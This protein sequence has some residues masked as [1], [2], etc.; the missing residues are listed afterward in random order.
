MSHE[1]IWLQ[2]GTGDDTTWCQY[3]INADDIE[4]VRADLLEAKETDLWRCTVCGRVGTVGRCC[5]EETRERANMGSLQAEIEA[6]RA[7][8]ERLREIREAAVDV[9]GNAIRQESGDYVVFSRPLNRLIAALSQPATEQLFL[10]NT[11]RVQEAAEK[12]LDELE[13]LTDDELESLI[14]RESLPLMSPKTAARVLNDE[15]QRPLGRRYRVTDTDEHGLPV[16]P[17][18]PGM[19]EGA[20]YRGWTEST[21]RWSYYTRYIKRHAHDRF[22]RIEDYRPAAQEGGDA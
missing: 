7:E 15:A 1:R 20:R 3:R 6:L 10:G 9:M 14:E 18:E 4:Y 21:Q 22:E 5:G 12:A 11:A 17:R 19:P 8:M 2:Q 16:V 13:R